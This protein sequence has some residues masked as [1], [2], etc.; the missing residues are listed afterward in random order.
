[1]VPRVESLIVFAGF[2]L[3]YGIVLQRSG[4]CFARAGFELFLLR[5]RDAFNG[6]MAGLVVATVGFTVVAAVRGSLGRDPTAHLL[7][8]PLG[9][10]TLLGGILFGAGMTLAGMCAAG[11]L[12]RLGEGYLVAWFTFTG[13]IVGAVLDPFSAFRPGKWTLQL[14][15]GL[16]L[17]RQIGVIGGGV[18]AVA[19]LLLIWLVVARS[20]DAGKRRK[21]GASRALL[22]PTVIGGALLGLINTVQMAVVTPWTV[23]YPLAAVQAA[24]AHELSAAAVHR[25]APYIALDLGLVLGALVASARSGLR[26][27][28]PRR[29]RE[30]VTALIGG[31]LMAWG[32]QL[33]KG[34]SI[35]GVFSA[36]PSLSIGGWLFFPSLFLGAWI[37]SQ[38]VRRAR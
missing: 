35:G 30:V 14:P 9:A 2:G 34:C 16:W 19:A 3:A 15:G 8:L 17:G 5:S 25:A 13:A 21:R 10:G 22:T 7:L 12:Q 6:V 20:Q 31:A 24:A 33:A 38:V 29:L 36:V 28:V 27:K 26:M 11:T 4:F 37:G 18:A 32:V 23:T 1:M